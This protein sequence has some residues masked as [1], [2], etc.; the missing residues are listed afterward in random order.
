MF[1]KL[2]KRRSKKAGLSPGTL[3]HIGEQK[4]EYVELSVIDYNSDEAEFSKIDTPDKILKYIKN[5]NVS[6]LNVCGLHQPEII[7]QI[8]HEFGIH[9][10]VLEDI[11]NTEQRPKVEIYDDYIFIVVKML[12]YDEK[13]E[14]LD[15]EQLSLILGKNFVITFQEKEGDVFDRLRE[16]IKKGKGRLRKKGADYLAY[17]LVDAVVDHY[18][19]VLEKFGDEIE[20]IEDNVY[21]E[22]DSDMVSEIQRIKSDMIFIRKSVWPLRESINLLMRDETPFIKEENII[23]L[24]DLYD[25]TIQVIDTIE[26]FREMVSSLLD[27]YLSSISNRMNEVMK[28]LTIIATIFIPLTFIAGIYGMN[29]EYMPELKIPWAYPAV[30]IVCILIAIIM[31]IFFRRKKWL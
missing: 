24:R 15:V 22:P 26:I 31:L 13:K 17:A 20:K 9:S 11:L 3:I 7:D 1:K 6:W 27:V 30:L 21:L 8:G 10:L 14:G 12:Q 19:L 16:W 18:F 28:V 29:F 25:H 23:F 5:D 2:R 4:T